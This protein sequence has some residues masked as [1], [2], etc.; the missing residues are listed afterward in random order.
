MNKQGKTKKDVPENEHTAPSDASSKVIENGSRIS[1]A[2]ENGKASGN[3]PPPV[4]KPN[5]EAKP[6]RLYNAIMVLPRNLPL[7][8]TL[9]SY[10]EAYLLKRLHMAMLQEHQQTIHRDCW[11]NHVSDLFL[12]VEPLRKDAI[13]VLSKLRRRTDAG[14]DRNEGMKKVYEDHL[15]YVI[16]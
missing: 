12:E 14:I 9:F 1:S 15:R 8:N 10:L 3:A 7:A 16:C 4:K 6:S 13:A 2:G 11:S 5:G